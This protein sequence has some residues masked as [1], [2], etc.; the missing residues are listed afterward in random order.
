[1]SDSDILQVN[2]VTKVYPN[3][4]KGLD[5]ISFNVKRGEF[6]A[7][8]G[9]SGAGKSTLFRSIN[10]MQDITNGEIFI[11]GTDISKLKGKEL[12]HFRRKIGMIFQSFNLVNRLTV[13]K[14]V[15]SGRVGYY[16]TWK[17]I[18]G[19]YSKGDKE[20]AVRSLDHVNML[21]KLYDRADSLSGGQMQR[22][23]IARTMMQEPDLV[24]ADEPVAS[25]D[26]KTSEG[27]MKDLRNLNVKDHDT[28]LVNLHSIDLALEFA[29]RIIGIR[30]G[31]LVFD[32][33]AAQ[34]TPDDLKEICEGGNS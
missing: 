25:L 19:L 13:Q 2:H 5:D 1:M 31:Q 8:V 14:N 15:L 27:V 26:P 9:L 6:I 22:V 32:K 34:S 12:R 3:G 33:A 18:L 24:L 10:R 11:N 29:D 30:D 7:V 23:A 16:S 17:T 4:I 28:V 20:K 21:K